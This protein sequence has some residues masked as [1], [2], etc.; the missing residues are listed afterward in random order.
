MKQLSITIFIFISFWACRQKNDD[1]AG[2]IVDLPVTFNEGFG[3]FGSSYSILV[4]EYTL[5][6]P[7]GAGWVKTY[8]PVKGIPKA[9]KQVVK[10]MVLL[11]IRQ[12]VYQN[13]HKGNIDSS[14]Y[15]YLQKSWDWQPDANQLS[16]TPI[17]CYVYVVR[18]IDKSGK[19][20]VM[21]DSNNNLDF[22]DELPFYPEIASEKDTLRHYK[23]FYPVEYDVFR[24]GKVMTSHVPMII[25]YLPHKPANMNFY[26]SFP[27]YAT[28]NINVSDEEYIIAV[29][30]DFVAPFSGEVSELALID[31]NQKAGKI[32]LGHGIAKGE[33]I[34]IGV[35]KQKKRYKNLGFNAQKSVLQLQGEPLIA[36]S[37]STQTGFLFKSFTGNEFSSGKLISLK[38]YKG[39]YLFID[40][41]GTWCKPCVE[42]L[43]SL[44]RLHQNINKDQIAFLGIASHDNTESLRGFL[45]K[46]PVLWHQ[47]LSDSSNKIMETY[48]VE[49]FP[50]NF[51]IDPDGRI[52]A[53]NLHKEELENKLK[54]LGCLN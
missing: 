3:P 16:K 47:I 24:E 45:K 32:N 50:S 48:N 23:K 42:E 8:L 52:V 12:L 14:M 41:W 27:Q 54:E 44:T 29:N 28:T 17:R 25:K 26:Y 22:A 46:K 13:F 10:S 6:N 11:D 36:Q 34:D 33:F 7:S 18:G 53:K 4:A 40:F 49:M 9:W 19:R 35:G 20:A 38:D 30:L 37:Y 39:K 43:P 51:I 15:Q 5:D 2:T 31:K 21:I 1:H